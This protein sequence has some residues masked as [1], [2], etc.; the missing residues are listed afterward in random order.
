MN[1]T[2]N[3][4]LSQWAKSDRVLMDDFNA[5]NAKI[6][7]AIAAKVAIVTG[8][9]KGDGQE[10]RFIDLGFT[11]KALFVTTASGVTASPSSIIHYG[12]MALPDHPVTYDHDPVVAIV[13]NGFQ[14]TYRSGN[15]ILSNENNTEFF[16]LALK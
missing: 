16:Y 6:D 12:G 3:Y 14:V 15:H 4:Q 2:P 8:T 9:Y 7:A 11:P 10:F 13:E 5:D 1:H